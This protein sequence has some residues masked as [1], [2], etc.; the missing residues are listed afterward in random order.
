LQGIKYWK[1]EI[2]SN[3]IE[4][5]SGVLKRGIWQFSPAAALPVRLDNGVEIDIVERQKLI[6]AKNE[7][8]KGRKRGMEYK[9]TAVKKED[10]KKAIA[11]REEVKNCFDR[12]L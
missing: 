7:L 3:K 9:E 6:E 8:I 11:A 12:T 5:V 4:K 10:P 1:G 2:E